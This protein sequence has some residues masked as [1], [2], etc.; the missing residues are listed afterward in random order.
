MLRPNDVGQSEPVED[1]SYS[2]KTKYMS[3]D[4]LRMTIFLF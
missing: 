3:F 2:G 4:K 1:I